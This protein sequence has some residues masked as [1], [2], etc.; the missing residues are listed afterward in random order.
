[1]GRGVEIGPE[2]GEMGALTVSVDLT[3]SCADA[4][5]RVVRESTEYRLSYTCSTDATGSARPRGN[6]PPP[7]PSS[8][9]DAWEY[10]GVRSRARR[11]GDGGSVA[12]LVAQTDLCDKGHEAKSA[13]LQGTSRWAVK[14]SNL[15]PWVKNCLRGF[16]LPFGRSGDFRL[17]D[18]DHTCHRMHGGWCAGLD[19][20]CCPV[21]CPLRVV[22]RG[23]GNPWCAVRCWLLILDAGPRILALWNRHAGS[24]S[25]F[26]SSG[27]RRFG[28]AGAVGSSR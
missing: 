20:V 14:G 1:M 22:D 10:R 19:A 21:C 24:G 13:R 6:G 23:S 27:G 4:G 8:S 25:M 2:E 26:P 11:S 5:R 9:P 15:R 7:V 18:W 16:C 28:W 3:M 17:G 12:R